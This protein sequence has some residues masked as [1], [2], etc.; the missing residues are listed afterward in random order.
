MGR[1][2]PQPKYH[3]SRPRACPVGR[4]PAPAPGPPYRAR[5]SRHNARRRRWRHSWP[6]SGSSRSRSPTRGHRGQRRGRAAV[7]S[8]RGSG[9]R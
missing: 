8:L 5:R 7:P 2:S 4:T 3:H 6:R 1:A 9:I